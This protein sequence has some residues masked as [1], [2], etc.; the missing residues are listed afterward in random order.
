[1]DRLSRD[2][3]K[4]KCR[5]GRLE[6]DLVLARIIPILEDDEVSA[7]DALL[8]LPDDD[9]WDIVVGR[10]NDFDPALNPIVA[11]LRAV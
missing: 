10:R 4:W 3:L 8:D 1:M 5:R 7:F 2:R 6:L 9:L 11:R